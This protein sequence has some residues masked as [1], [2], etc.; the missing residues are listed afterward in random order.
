MADR[1]RWFNT[2][3]GLYEIVTVDDVSIKHFTKNDKFKCINPTCNVDMNLR[4]SSKGGFAFSSYPG[5]AK[6]HVDL[7]NCI[8]NSLTFQ[9]AKYCEGKFFFN[10]FVQKLLYDRSSSPSGRAQ[11]STKSNKTINND[12]RPALRGLSSFYRMV[13]SKSKNDIYNGQRVGDMFYDSEN[14]NE[15]VMNP[16][17]YKVLECSYYHPI[18]KEKAF[19]INFPIDNR[20]FN[21]STVKIIIKNR[22]YFNKLANEIF[23]GSK[24]IEP[25]VIA[26]EWIRNDI[27]NSGYIAYCVIS[28]ERQLAY[29]KYL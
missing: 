1:A 13:A 17:G 12:P 26:G 15:F 18:Y 8:R 25:L 19:I 3:T 24:H 21:G 29:L 16:T 11:K 20:H 27:P 2:K 28:S 9:S 4:N 14:Y 7:T 5:Q 23:S 22:E 6:N 10:E